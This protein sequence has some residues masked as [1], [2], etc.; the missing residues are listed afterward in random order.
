MKISKS[1]YKKNSPDKNE[2]E[3]LIPSKHITTENMA[4][5]ILA[6]G[7]VLFPDTGDYYFPEGLVHEKPIMQDAGPFSTSIAR[8][9][10]LAMDNFFADSNN[11]ERKSK[12]MLGNLTGEGIVNQDAF[13]DNTKSIFQGKTIDKKKF[14]PNFVPALGLF[15]TAINKFSESQRG[16]ELE[17][18][19]A[20][21]QMM[22]NMR[23]PI[24][25]TQYGQYGNPYVY[26]DGGQIDENVMNEWNKYV[27]YL[28]STG[29][30]GKPEL[31]KN[32]LGF[33]KLEEYRSKNKN[34]VL[35][36]EVIPQ[37]QR[38]LQDYRNWVI[39]GH[40]T[41]KRPVQFSYEVAP[42]YSNFMPNLSK[43]DGYPGQYTTNVR[44]PSEY[45][46][47]KRVGFAK[48]QMQVGGVMQEFANFAPEELPTELLMMKR[49]QAQS[50]VQTFDYEVGPSDIRSAIL[51]RESSG[52]YEA[53]PYKK[54]G[55]LASSA[56]GGYQFL[57]NKHKKD[58]ER[59][60]G[61][62]S[63]EEF[64]KN[65][66]AQD[67][68]FDFWE[69]NVLTP[70]AIAIKKALGN[71]APDL[72]QIKM[73]IHFA[74]PKGAKDFFFTGKETK[75]AF[76]TTTSKYKEGGEYELSQEEIQD[77]INNGGT[78]EYL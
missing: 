76:G 33:Q 29:F 78:V 34:T 42:D 24:R 35:T 31:D 37:I 60:T 13:T 23:S 63:K 52:N 36:K 65:P 45:M 28:E 61:V 17:Q 72:N 7:K 20:R 44:F 41:G 77:I 59:I 70:N 51:E 73:K 10:D 27:D 57:W 49:A 54:D 38:Q 3:L 55:S 64:R 67:M 6:N 48:P 26:Q 30:K 9:A 5:P 62:K 58:I 50:N 1:G 39:E 75:D 11:G 66:A 32:N 46:M 15:N 22:S 47:G 53:L 21:M 18:E 43:V 71:K 2:E 14:S 16:K 8:E 4:F 56:V 68:Y 19:Y 74:G 40:K 25:L 12:D 69:Q